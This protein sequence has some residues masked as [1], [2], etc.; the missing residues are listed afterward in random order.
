VTADDDDAV[1]ERRNVDGIFT[2]V[3]H[4]P[5]EETSPN[6][7]YRIAGSGIVPTAPFQANGNTRV[8]ATLTTTTTTTAAV[9]TSATAGAHLFTVDMMLL[10]DVGTSSSSKDKSGL[11][12]ATGT[13]MVMGTLGFIAGIALLSAAKSEARI[14]R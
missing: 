1:L 10:A 8:F 3:C 4:A 12:W 13:V 2:E 6:G 5:C 7:L 14:T 9:V 11:D